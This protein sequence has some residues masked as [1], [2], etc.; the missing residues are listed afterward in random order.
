M[1]QYFCIFDSNMQVSDR[2]RMC[3]CVSVARM[4]CCVSVAR[5]FTRRPTILRYA[6]VA[7]LVKHVNNFLLRILIKLTMTEETSEML[8]LEHGSVWC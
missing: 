5:M 4:C 8:R 1:Q 3:C 6:Y 2:R 7:Y